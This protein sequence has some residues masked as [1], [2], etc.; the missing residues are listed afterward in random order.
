M[1]I[2]HTTY[3]EYSLPDGDVADTD[4]GRKLRE[5]VRALMAALNDSLQA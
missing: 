5:N 1:N 2:D 4:E 3:N